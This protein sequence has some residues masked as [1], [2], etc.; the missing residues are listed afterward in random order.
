MKTKSLKQQ[1]E[2]GCKEKRILNEFDKDRVLN[3]KLP[4]QKDYLC[5]SCKKQLQLLDKVK[6]I[7]NKL[8]NNDNGTL[9]EKGY[10]RCK[11]ELL[12]ALFGEE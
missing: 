12:N 3:I 4:C 8:D 9:Y 7:I 1:I 5:P 10:D 6:E 11:V 2:E